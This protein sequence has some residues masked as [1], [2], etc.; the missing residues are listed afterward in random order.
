MGND[1]VLDV[2]RHS[3]FREVLICECRLVSG[4]RRCQVSCPE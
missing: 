1:Y 2:G 3:G 4:L